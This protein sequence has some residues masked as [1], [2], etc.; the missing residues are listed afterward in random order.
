MAHMSQLANSSSCRLQNSIASGSVKLLP[1]IEMYS[2]VGIATRLVGTD[3]VNRL[4]SSWRK[5]KLS[6][7]PISSGIDP[8]S[9]LRSKSM[10]RNIDALPISVGM[11]PVNLFESKSMISNDWRRPIHVGKLPDNMFE[12]ISS[13]TSDDN[14]D[15][16]GSLPDSPRSSSLKLVTSPLLLQLTPS[17]E[18]SSPLE[19]KHTTSASVVQF[20]PVRL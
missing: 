6:N 14:R 17:Q 3:P 12:S 18:H 4:K 13:S 8:D 7:E 5:Y 15:I 20:H 10:T 1:M 2:R 9:L 16:S 11:V 19:R